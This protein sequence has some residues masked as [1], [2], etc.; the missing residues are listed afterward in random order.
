MLQTLRM[1]RFILVYANKIPRHVI[2]SWPTVGVDGWCT[3]W[4]LRTKL[5]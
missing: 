2:F 1:L 5:G 3:R 4:R